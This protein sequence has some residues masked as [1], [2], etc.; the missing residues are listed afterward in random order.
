M[1]LFEDYIF[2]DKI[3][4]FNLVKLIY[5]LNTDIYDFV[6]LN[7]INDNNS[8]KYLGFPTLLQFV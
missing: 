3:I 8:F 2:L 7:K 4:D 1:A 5:D 6:S